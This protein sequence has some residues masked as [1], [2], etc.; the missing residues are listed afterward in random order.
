MSLHKYSNSNNSSLLGRN[1]LLTRTVPVWVHLSWTKLILFSLAMI[2][3]FYKCSLI[4]WIV[5]FDFFIGILQILYLQINGAVRSSRKTRIQI[6][7]T[8]SLPKNKR[9]LMYVENVYRCPVFA[10]SYY[11]EY[12]HVKLIATTSDFYMQSCGKLFQFYACILVH[13]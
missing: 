3:Y 4:L 9:L 13:L 11:L 1:S 8:K 12:C 10:Q 7:F 5:F 6:S 2:I